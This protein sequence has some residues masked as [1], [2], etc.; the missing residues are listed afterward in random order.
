MNEISLTLPAGQAPDRP[1]RAAA[2]LV[3][4]VRSASTYLAF[5]SSV[6]FTLAVVFGMLN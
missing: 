2:A 6:G 1:F 3:S 5:A 4:T